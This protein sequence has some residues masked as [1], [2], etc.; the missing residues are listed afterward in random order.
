MQP[1]NTS[2]ISDL[3]APLA[4]LSTAARPRS[5]N[6][7]GASR[8]VAASTPDVERLLDLAREPEVRFRS[9]AGVAAVPRGPCGLDAYALPSVGA[10]QGHGHAGDVAE[11]LRRVVNVV[12]AAVA[13]VALAPLMT[14][15]ALAIRLTSRGPIIYVQE[16]VGLDRRR[17]AGEDDASLARAERR[18]EDVGG[19]PYRMYK[20][21]TMRVN[22]EADGRPVWAAKD[23][24]RVTRVGRVLRKTRLD[25]LPQLVNVLRGEMNLV[26]PRPERPAIAAQLSR[27]IDGYALRYRVRPGIT[28]WAQVNH[29][30]DATLDDVRAK[31]RYD[32]E[33][34][35]RIQQRGVTGV[36]ED[37]RILA[38]TV[39]V[40]LGRRHGW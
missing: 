31:V 33:Y 24:P 17:R 12:L 16:R 18:R 13:L 34:L 25:E 38:R 4:G 26:G 2:D 36:A 9:A 23:D 6:G 32:L 15:L 5:P 21:R 22:A 14:L 3:G 35:D 37:L 40:M 29:P 30:Y 8:V 28:G 20:F 11:A 10:G 19:A 39:P 1:T 7:P 27:Q